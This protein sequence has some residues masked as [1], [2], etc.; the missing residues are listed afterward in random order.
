MGKDVSSRT[1][2]EELADELSAARKMRRPIA[3]ISKT[4]I[5]FTVDDA[6]AVQEVA[7]VRRLEAGERI[8][9]HKIGLTSPA[10]QAQ[11]GVSEP[12]F[13][14][15][16]DA[17]RVIEG[18]TVP[19]DILIQPKV[20]AEIA[21]VLKEGLENGPV[22]SEM[23]ATA[24]DYAVAAV[25]IVDSAI[26]DWKITLPD[27]VADNASAAKFL[28]GSDRMPLERIDLHLAGMELLHNGSQAS[29]GVAA[30]C[31]GN[32]LNAVAWL[33]NKMI[34]VGRPLS[35]GHI[36]LSGAL[37]PMVAVEAGDEISVRVQGFQPLHLSFE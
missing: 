35:R 21:F 27:T 28:I 15:L 22:T 36:V 34:E 24:I 31:L 26:E 8:V 25:E 19:M 23:V 33:A 5:G 30:A 9:G 13:G 32:P 2:S 7:T 20:E 14:M 37:G 6:Y 11:L 3:P 16:F 4:H 18:K 1:I 10:V 29:V 12:D 17:D